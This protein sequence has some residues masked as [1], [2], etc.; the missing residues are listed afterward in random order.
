MEISNIIKV[1]YHKFIQTE[2]IDELYNE[3]SHFFHEIALLLVIN[4]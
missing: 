2:D 3:I 4:L 1:G